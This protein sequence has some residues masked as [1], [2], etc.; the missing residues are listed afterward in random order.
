MYQSSTQQVMHLVCMLVAGLVPACA[1]LDCLTVFSLTVAD[2]AAVMAVMEAAGHGP[3][4]VWRR[5][6]VNVAPP[7][8]TGFRFAVPSKA[9]LDW[10]CPGEFEVPAISGAHCW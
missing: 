1:S 9:L 7:P 6:R 5:R 2:G 3:L 4:D 10:S 8:S